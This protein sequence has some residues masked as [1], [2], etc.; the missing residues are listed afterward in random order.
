M[1]SRLLSAV[2]VSLTVVSLPLL[3]ASVP[4]QECIP[5]TGPASPAP[6]CRPAA[7]PSAPPAPV[8]TQLPDDGVNGP[9]AG[10]FV[11]PDEASTGVPDGVNLTPLTPQNILAG[12][13]LEGGTLTI[14]TPNAVYD[15][16]DIPYLVRNRAHGTVIR[17][18]HVRGIPGVQSDTALVS[19]DGP[20]P[21]GTVPLLYVER[22]TLIP[23][24]PSR[25]VD[26][27]R[28]SNIALRGVEI[29][30][31]VDGVHVF[32]STEPNDPAAGHIL[33]AGSWVHDLAQLPDPD[34]P[35]G[36]VHADGVQVVGGSRL[37]LLGNNFDLDS[38]ANAAIMSKPDRSAIADT[39]AV[40]N[41]MSGGGCSINTAPADGENLQ[42]FQVFSLN[43]FERGSTKN[44]DCAIVVPQEIEAT[45]LIRGNQWSDKSAPP[46]NLIPASGAVGLYFEGDRWVFDPD[47]AKAEGTWDQSR[48][49]ALQRAG[50]FIGVDL[51]ELG[52]RFG[53]VA[54]QPPS[55]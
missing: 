53:T 52:Q 26:G 10:G 43:Q 14:D 34:Q 32:G 21:D 7:G 15:G 51:Q 47:R 24:E 20:Q 23:D 12:D 29:S 5:V 28:G 42:P 36:V 33:M 3:T 1:R 27:V 8:P 4:A 17:N 19:N 11:K 2:V 39:M 54:P 41:W 45:T 35:D 50:Q 49:E 25:H 40:G 48:A 31:V 9:E 44:K 30:G 22:S 55:G 38:K 37:L 18:S 16:F 46:P 6:Y 13:T